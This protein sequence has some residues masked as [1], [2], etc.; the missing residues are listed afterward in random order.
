MNTQLSPSPE[1]LSIMAM[2]HFNKKDYKNASDLFLK[3]LDGFKKN[4]DEIMVAETKNNLSV[5]FLLLGDSQ[6]ALDYAQGTDTIFKEFN[7]N[8]RQ[9]MA[10]GNQAAA[11]EALNRIPEAIERYKQSS[12]ILMDSDENELRSY[13]LKNLSTLQL[14]HGQQLE[15]VATMQ[16][17]MNSKKKLS[18]KEK[19]LKKLLDTPFRLMR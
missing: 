14:K 12:E 2:R 3:A 1:D 11:Y 15:A 10:L 18:L 8:K 4:N 5:A 19:V 6:A 9:A 16:A 17:A 7:D 13:L